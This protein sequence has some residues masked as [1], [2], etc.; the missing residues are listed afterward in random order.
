M[1]G[2]RRVRVPTREEITRIKA[3]LCLIRNAT[4]DYVD[5]AA[6]ANRLGPEAAAVVLERV[7]ETEEAS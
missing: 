6:L 2:S 1:A 5:V 4:R 7:A 3:W